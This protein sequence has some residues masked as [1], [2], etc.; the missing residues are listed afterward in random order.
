MKNTQIKICCFS[1]EK[2][3]SHNCQQPHPGPTGRTESQSTLPYLCQSVF[4]RGKAS[5]ISGRTVAK[6]L[7]LPPPKK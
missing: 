7:W 2:V 5:I 1:D 6:V 4:C 3:L